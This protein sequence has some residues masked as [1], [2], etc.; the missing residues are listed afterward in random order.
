[1]GHYLDIARRVMTGKGIEGTPSVTTTL[2]YE[3]TPL[4]LFP[5]EA[6]RAHSVRD[7]GWLVGGM[8]PACV[9]DGRISHLYRLAAMGRSCRRCGSQA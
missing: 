9:A 4:S 8:C 6:G 2:R 5:D 1:M 3:P 7:D